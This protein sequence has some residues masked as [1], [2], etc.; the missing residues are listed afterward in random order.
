MELEGWTP[1][2]SDLH[3]NC[4]QSPGL[5]TSIP[6]IPLTLQDALSKPCGRVRSRLL[7]QESLTISQSQAKPSFSNLTAEAKDLQDPGSLEFMSEDV[8]AVSSRGWG[9]QSVPSSPAATKSSS[10]GPAVPDPG[11]QAETG[12]PPH[13]PGSGWGPLTSSAL[14]STALLFPPLLLLSLPK[15]KALRFCRCARR[16]S[17]IYHTISDFVGFFVFNIEMRY[18]ALLSW[19]IEVANPPAWDR[20]SF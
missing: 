7:N 11:E 4:S 13:Q 8:T 16:L 15:Q 14:L 10:P 6:F 1:P 18:T 9:V 19:N 3:L 17:V 5:L 2:A 20:L 12:G